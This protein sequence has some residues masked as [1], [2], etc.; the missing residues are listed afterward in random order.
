MPLEG[1]GQLARTWVGHDLEPFT[2]EAQ[3]S[4]L[5]AF[6]KATRQTDAVFT[7]TA[8]AREQGLKGLLAPPTFLFCLERHAPQPDLLLELLGADP[9]QRLLHAE[10]AFTYHQP[11]HAGDVLTFRQRL[12]DV[13][14]KKGGDLQF[15][16]RTT[17]VT[18]QHDQRVAELRHVLTLVNRPIQPAPRQTRVEDDATAPLELRTPPITRLDL[19]LYACA[20]GDFNPVHIDSDFAREAGF[21]DVF[22]HGMLVMAQAARP[23]TDWT[24][25]GLSQLSIR[26]E[27]IT[28]IG[29]RLRCLAQPGERDANGRHSVSLAV[30]DQHGERKASGTAVIAA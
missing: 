20:S 10:Q 24:R 25:T 17:V 8:A 28:H 11:V 30:H 26:F 19:A 29:D 14:E 6:S 12:A 5:R 9:R 23:L 1:A 16:V 15:A 21:D 2:V 4:V 7:D 18:N 22:V 13:F 27:R 3:E